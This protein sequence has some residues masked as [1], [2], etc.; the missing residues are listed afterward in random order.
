MILRWSKMN[1]TNILENGTIMHFFRFLRAKK[2][3]VKMKND[4]Q[5]LPPVLLSVCSLKCKK[6]SWADIHH[7]FSRFCQYFIAGLVHGF[8]CATIEL[9]IHLRVFSYAL[10]NFHD[11]GFPAVLSKVPQASIPP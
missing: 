8:T 4:S 10:N 2:F 9:W 3:V 11:V 1:S 6:F 5:C 7:K